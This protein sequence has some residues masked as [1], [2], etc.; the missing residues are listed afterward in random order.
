M[1]RNKYKT[2][3]YSHISYGTEPTKFVKYL[4]V[5]PLRQLFNFFWLNFKV[6]RIVVKG[7]S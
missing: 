5:A 2:E 1:K 4:R 6:M 3:P 7:H